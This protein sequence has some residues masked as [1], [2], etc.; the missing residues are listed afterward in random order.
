MKVFRYVAVLITVV[1]LAGACDLKTPADIASQPAGGTIKVFREVD[2]EVVAIDE[3]EHPLE[4]DTVNVIVNAYDLEGHQALYRDKESNEF[5]PGPQ[6]L[7]LRFVPWEYTATIGDA[8]LV[9]VAIE[10]TYQATEAGDGVFCQIY[11]TG[12]ALPLAPENIAFSSFNGELVKVKCSYE[13]IAR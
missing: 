1:L 9:K 10:V 12:K 2:F 4:G 13:Y 6:I 5:V 3:D 8:R 7:P 11:V